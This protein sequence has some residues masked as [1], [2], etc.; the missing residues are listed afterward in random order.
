MIIHSAIRQ[1][2]E[3]L[4]AFKKVVKDADAHQKICQ[5]AMSIIQGFNLYYGTHRLEKLI[6]LLDTANLHDFY[7]F[8]KL[9]YT[10]MYPFNIERLDIS[11]LFKSVKSSEHENLKQFLEK[12]ADKGRGYR[13]VDEFKSA[14][15][16]NNPSLSAVEV[17][18]KPIS[19][20]ESLSMASFTF[21]T[22]GY[23]PLFLQEWRV[24]D[25]SVIVHQLGRFKVSKWTTTHSLDQ[26]VRGGLCVGFL[27]RFIEA[28]WLLWQGQTSFVDKRRAQWDLVTGL[29]EFIFNYAIFRGSHEG[30][31]IA[32]TF[33]AKSFGLLSIFYKPKMQVKDG[34]SH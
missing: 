14:L 23:V 3:Y 30:V 5:V 34:L 29:T 11:Q 24:I 18:L 25:L 9:P 1:G 8:L 7:E 2:I 22:I 28:F 21:V 31:I 27:V 6:K 20:L 26:W 4:G 13:T 10:L 15:A 17:H 19:F 32:M 12:M 16:R 33:I